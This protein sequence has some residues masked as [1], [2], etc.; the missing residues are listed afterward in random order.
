MALLAKSDIAAAGNRIVAPHFTPLKKMYFQDLARKVDAG[1]AS[2]L[3]Q[4]AERRMNA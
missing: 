3:A 2:A 1:F 4:A